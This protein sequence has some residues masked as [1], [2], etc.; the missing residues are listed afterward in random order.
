MGLRRTD[1]YSVFSK[2]RE[3]EKKLGFQSV[4]V[5]DIRLKKQYYLREVTVFR[6]YVL[7]RFPRRDGLRTECLTSKVRTA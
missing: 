6:L 4:D 2:S 1:S 7:E 3:T 5:L